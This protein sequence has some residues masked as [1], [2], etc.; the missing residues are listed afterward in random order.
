MRILCTLCLGTY[1]EATLD[2]LGPWPIGFLG[3]GGAKFWTLQVVCLR[4]GVFS[5]A[6]IAAAW[7]TEQKQYAHYHKKCK[8]LSKRTSM[9]KCTLMRLIFSS[10]RL[11]TFFN[12]AWN[13][14]LAENKQK[15]D[16]Q[17]KKYFCFEKYWGQIRANLNP[18][19]WLQLR[20]FTMR[21]SL[22]RLYIKKK[23]NF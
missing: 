10:A 17:L 20:S 21:A 23:E 3:P 2:L 13:R 11:V 22:F 19:I 9:N 16:S 14:K 8:F 18:D 7:Y 15:F 4:C 6:T 12:S 1:L 5:V